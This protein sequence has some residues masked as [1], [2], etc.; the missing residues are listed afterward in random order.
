MEMTCDLWDTLTL[1]VDSL[2]PTSFRDLVEDFWL[3]VVGQLAQLRDIE[4]SGPSQEAWFHLR[5]T[6]PCADRIEILRLKRGVLSAQ[7]SESIRLLGQTESPVRWACWCPER[8]EPHIDNA[9]LSFLQKLSVLRVR[10]GICYP[11]FLAARP[12][13]SRYDLDSPC[14]DAYNIMMRRTARWYNPLTPWFDHMCSTHMDSTR[15][16]EYAHW[17]GHIISGWDGA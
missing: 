14:Q 9:F 13:S 3:K 17:F 2:T 6:N 11:Q 4:I 10:D 16:H 7:D 12:Q 8:F 15:K 1:G 5:R